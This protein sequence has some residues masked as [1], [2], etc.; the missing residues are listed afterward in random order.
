MPPNAAFE[1]TREG[2]SVKGHRPA[3]AAR[4]ISRDEAIDEY[5]SLFRRGVERRRPEGDYI[6]PLSGG[7]DSRHILLEL[8][9]MGCPPRQCITSLKD[10]NLS[11]RNKDTRLAP[12]VA[13][14]LGIP[15]RF[16]TEQPSV[17]NDRAAFSR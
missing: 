8:C 4:P 14:R 15:H 16:F 10:P 7:R 17:F 2:L 6:M 1:W 11:S 9:R 12:E 5:I 13:A 3:F